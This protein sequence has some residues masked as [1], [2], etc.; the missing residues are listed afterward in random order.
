MSILHFEQGL[1]LCN[2]AKGSYHKLVLF[3]GASN[4]GKTDLLHK[5]ASHLQIPFLNVGYRLSE[6]ILPLSLK[7]RSFQAKEKLLEMLDCYDGG[8][9]M[10][11]TEFLLSS[12]LLLNPIALLQEISRSRLILASWNG[13]IDAGRLTS[14]YQGHPDFFEHSTEGILHLLLPDKTEYA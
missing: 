14:G 9:A 1:N 7:Q 12:F 4:H 2:S 13:H 8:V 5:L 11:N 3:V 10:D 6:A